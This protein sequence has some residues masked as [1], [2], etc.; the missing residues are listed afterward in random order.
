MTQG[1]A[2]TALQAVTAALEEEEDSARHLQFYLASHAFAVPL[3]VLAEVLRPPAISPVP[4]APPCL[5][6]LAN[7][8]GAV[9][10]VLDLRA[11]LRLPTTNSPNARVLVLQ[12]GRLVGVLVD[13]VVNVMQAEDESEVG[14]HDVQGLDK[15]LLHSVVREGER[16]AF[17]LD[18]AG[19]LAREFPEA[20]AGTLHP[21]T[22]HAG[23]SG[24]QAAGTEDSTLRLVCF[25]VYGQDYALPITV[26]RA[27]IAIPDK[28][29]A[30]P[31]A[32]ASVL[33]IIS[34]HDNLLPVFHLNALLGLPQ[35]ATNSHS[36]IVVVAVTLNGQSQIAGLVVDKVSEVLQVGE[37]SL[38]PVPALLDQNPGE[39]R[40]SAICH[41]GSDQRLFGVLS[42]SALLAAEQ[43]QNLLRH[44][45]P[46]DT[47]R[48]DKQTEGEVAETRIVVLRLLDAEFGLPI[49][50]VEEI[51]RV[52][53]LAPV[54]KAPEFVL[55]VM[56][57]RGAVIP[58]LNP[59]RRLG[60][61]D[62]AAHAGQRVLIVSI[63]GERSG[64]LVDGVTAVLPV[65][66][67]NFEITPEFMH[68]HA[69]LVQRV[70]HLADGR[71]LLMLDLP[72]L[73]DEAALRSLAQI[74]TGATA[75]ASAA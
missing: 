46:A 30:M 6:G 5:L 2:S 52:T 35:E 22:H 64:I 55:G 56:N 50:A 54:P 16:V 66:D 63:Q 15:S 74:K 59:R 12:L 18:F 69:H 3:K 14:G 8:R 49:E 73:L 70:A 62:N 26:I 31:K 39:A 71:M 33:G 24:G 34:L 1:I 45:H 65:P 44:L 53:G 21:T 61:A 23:D 25:S 43:T 57:L 75:T 41:A 7:L 10:P 32:P 60:L 37:D 27:I 4:L 28:I 19:L 42:L 11:P 40:V 38:R 68:P 72:R 9:L 13:R 17:T 29:V 51:V 20:A 36:R 48:G 58:V 67:A 47:P